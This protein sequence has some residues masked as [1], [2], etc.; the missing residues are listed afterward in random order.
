M[1][2]STG[3]A[4]YRRLISELRELALFASSA[5]ILGWDQETGMPP[6][7][8]QLRADQLSALGAY[9]HQRY[10]RAEVGDWLALCEADE[11]LLADPRF[12]ANVREVRREYDREVLL[13]ESLVR[14]I[15]STSALALQAWRGAR[16]S[17]DFAAFAPWLEKVIDLARQKADCIRADRGLSRYDV[18]M[19]QYEPGARAAD[20]DG[21]FRDLRLQLTPLIA[22]IAEAAPAG[23]PVVQRGTIPTASQ[24]VLNREVVARM[25]FDFEA[26]RL[27]VST[28]PFCE[29][30]GPGDTR[31]TTRYRE[32]DFTESLSSA[33]H[34]AGHGL[35]EQGLPKEEHF[36]EP[37]SEATSLGIH[38]SQSRL[39]ENLV[40]RS[41]AFW[42][43]ATPLAAERFGAALEGI[44]A[45][46][47]YRTVNRVRPNLI[48]VDSDEATYNLHIMLRFDLERALLEG[49]LAVADLPGVWNERIR[50]DLGLEVPNDRLGCLQD[51]HWGMGAIGYFPTYTLGNLYAAQLWGAIRREIPDLEEE[52]ARG[53]FGRLLNWLRTH[54]H[55]FGR[56]LTA[57]E[58]C[59]RATGEP[60]SAAPF[61]AY[62]RAKFGELYGL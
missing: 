5:S 23:E 13:P 59:E 33:M 40:G 45:E 38:E 43:W 28:H 39:W 8:G 62:L 15:A 21:V 10:T 36:G 48:R 25:G 53:E 14:E 34:E 46:T 22:A 35:Y 26:G 3:L 49:D 55:H 18:L 27:D 42:R 32:D 30:I 57:A 60:L 52:M 2:E 6:R 44:G 54:V 9:V 56:Q 12:A 1:S 47:L 31:L 51:V 58:L 61:V 7:G 19:D 20:L 11:A 17:S 16:E 29:G 24:E 37:L 50:A 41:R 4:A